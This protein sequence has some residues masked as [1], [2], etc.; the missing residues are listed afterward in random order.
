[1]IDY[2]TKVVEKVY[3]FSNMSDGSREDYQNQLINGRHYVKFG[4]KQAV[5]LVG[6]LYKVYDPSVK[7]YK[8]VLHVGVAKQH[9]SDIVVSKQLGMETAHENALI[10]PACVMEVGS[11]W[12]RRHFIQFAKTYIDGLNLQF[13]KTAEELRLEQR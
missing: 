4:I 2:S 7:L 12:H 5:T 11:K 6:V 1:M 3:S 9:P 13:V 8:H 10:S